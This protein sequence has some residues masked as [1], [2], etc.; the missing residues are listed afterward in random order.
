MSKN[1]AYVGCRTGSGGAAVFVREPNS[2]KKAKG[3]FTFEPLDP[4]SYVLCHSP[5]GFEWGYCGSG[6]AQLAFAILMNFMARLP[7]DEFKEVRENVLSGA[8]QESLLSY[9]D[10]PRHAV[11]LV[12]YQQ[13]KCALVASAHRDHQLVIGASDIAMFLRR[14]AEC[15][16][17]PGFGKFVCP[18]KESPE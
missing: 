18:R 13:F 16:G 3:K 7:D 6:P 5:D 14:R 17:K 15:V 9:S 10:V 4:C 11:A 12:L 1:F 2:D 8:E